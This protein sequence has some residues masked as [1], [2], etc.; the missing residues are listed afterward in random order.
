[1]RRTSRTL[2]PT[3]S[4]GFQSSFCCGSCWILGGIFFGFQLIDIE[5]LGSL[6]ELG[7]IEKR[8]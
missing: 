4:E 8:N 3:A 6:M 5:E 1:M 7:L 2:V